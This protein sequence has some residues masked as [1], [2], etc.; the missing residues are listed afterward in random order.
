MKIQSAAQQKQL[1]Y[2]RPH[3]CHW[4]GDTDERIHKRPTEDQ[5][6]YPDPTTKLPPTREAGRKRAAPHI[7]TYIRFSD[8]DM[9]SID[10]AMVTSANLSTQAWGAATNNKGEVRICSWEVGV[11]FWPDL[12]VDDDNNRQ[13]PSNDVQNSEGRN[14]DV[15]ENARM[16]TCFRSDLPSQNDE[17]SPI[18]HTTIGFRMPYNLPLRPYGARDAPWCATASHS[19]PDWLGQTWEDA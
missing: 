1:T 18:P 4:A 2:L 9:E 7:K 12:F 15:C 13:L 16:V 19:E 14:Q 17:D 8:S 3:L 11:L 5:T 10:W 6:S